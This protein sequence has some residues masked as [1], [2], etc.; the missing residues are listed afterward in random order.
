MTAPVIPK[1]FLLNKI[2]LHSVKMLLDYLAF[3]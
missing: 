3:Q 1:E 2:P